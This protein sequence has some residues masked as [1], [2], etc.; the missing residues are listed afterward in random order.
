M[1]DGLQP[2]EDGNGICGVTHRADFS[3]DLA[4][5]VLRVRERPEQVWPLVDCGVQ[6]TT[7]QLAIGANEHWCGLLREFSKNTDLPACIEKQFSEELTIGVRSALCLLGDHIQD[8]TGCLTYAR[9]S[10]NTC[11]SQYLLLFS[12]QRLAL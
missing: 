12:A 11:D 2:L 6:F 8:V 7:E 10:S 3:S 9:H 1:A 4:S 5:G